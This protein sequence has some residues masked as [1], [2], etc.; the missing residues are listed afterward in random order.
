MNNLRKLQIQSVLSVNVMTKGVY[1]KIV[2][3]LKIIYCVP[4]IAHVKKMEN[5]KIMTKEILKD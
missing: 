5:A 2:N 4:Q 3:A 1:N